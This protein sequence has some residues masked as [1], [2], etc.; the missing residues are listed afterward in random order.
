MHTTSIVLLEFHPERNDLGK[1]KELRDGLSVAVQIGDTLWVTN[2]ETISLERLSLVEGGN[3]GTYRY[4]R[5][6]QQFSLNDYL[7]LPVPPPLIPRTWKRRT[8]KGWSTQTATSG[9]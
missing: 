8:W 9:W 1:D 2:D 4:G 5:H 6:H 7:R 3:T